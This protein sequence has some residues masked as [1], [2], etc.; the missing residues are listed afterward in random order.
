MQNAIREVN[1]LRKIAFDSETDTTTTGG[2]KQNNSKDYK[3]LGFQVRVRI[4]KFMNVH[5]TFLAF[6]SSK[7]T[8][9]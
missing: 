4:L 2:R 9:T 5:F 6:F 3:K 1:E 8:I 7:G